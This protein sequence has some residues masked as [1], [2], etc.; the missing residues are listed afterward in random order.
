MCSFD[1]MFVMNYTHRRCKRFQI[2]C[3]IYCLKEIPIDSKRGHYKCDTI[4]VI[5][6]KSLYNIQVKTKSTWL[7]CKIYKIQY[8]HISVVHVAEYCKGSI[9][10]H[11]VWMFMA[12]VEVI[13]VYLLTVS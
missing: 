8:T 3:V 2:S 4:N 13:R 11:N 5:P 12:Q 9:T 10:Q 7:Y 6:I 1:F